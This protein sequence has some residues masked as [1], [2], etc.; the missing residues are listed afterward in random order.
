ME[1]LASSGNTQGVPADALVALL[2]HHGVNEVLKWVDDFCLF[3]VPVS[4]AAD[5]DHAMAMHYSTDIDSIL[6]FTSPLGILWHPVVV[7]GQ[8]FISTVPYVGFLWDLDNRLVSLS[9]KKH[10]KYLEKVHALQVLTNS[11]VMHKQCMSV[12]GTLQH[13]TFV[14]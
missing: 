7:K 4:I 13:I 3:C 2:K 14:Y 9:S 8:D 1:G 5:L 12:H 11:K 6:A 10:L